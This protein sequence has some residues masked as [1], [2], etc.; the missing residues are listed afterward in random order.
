MMKFYLL[1]LNELPTTTFTLIANNNYL[2]ATSFKIARCQRPDTTQTAWPNVHGM[3]GI[4]WESG[5]SGPANGTARTWSPRGSQVPPTPHERHVYVNWC[6]GECRE[7]TGVLL[8][9][10]SALDMSSRRS[11][12][13]PTWRRVV[14]QSQK[15]RE[16]RTTSIE[17]VR[18]SDAYVPV[19]RRSSTKGVLYVLGKSR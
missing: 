2:Y 12:M 16:R 9:L 4:L 18:C 17:V 1:L 14:T 11:P 3:R 10:S 6:D 13:R 19:V 15:P 8:G 5:C 7:V